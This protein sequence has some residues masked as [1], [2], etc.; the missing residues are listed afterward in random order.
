MVG[1]CRAPAPPLRPGNLAF[2]LGSPN[3]LGAYIELLVPLS[4]V[5]VLRWVRARAWV[6]VLIGTAALAL[7]ATTSR[8]AAL[9]MGCGFVAFVGLRWSPQQGRRVLILTGM[10]V[11]GLVLAIPFLSRFAVGDAGRLELWHAAIDIFARWP[12]LGGG[13][14]SWPSLRPLSPITPSDT[15]VIATAHDA[16][17][18]VMAE[19]GIVGV[20]TASIV[21]VSVIAIAI[22]ARRATTGGERLRVDACTASLV[23]VAVHAL[24]DPMFHLA[25]VVVL[26]LYLVAQLEAATPTPISRPRVS[27]RT[28]RVLVGAWVIVAAVTL[29]RV[30]SAMLIA[31]GG[32]SALDRGDAANA[33]EAYDA[34]LALDDRD[35]YRLGG[36]SPWRIWVGPPRP[37]Q[38]SSRSRTRS[39]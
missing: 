26:V 17:L 10:S 36:P 35:G 32:D 30:D 16:P 6:A 9:G 25:G 13:P 18:Y 8:G 7:V 39:H 22:R 38:S 4:V 5:I 1:G 29:G 15:A 28:K 21:V 11:A 34:A 19:L 20:I 12:L 14:G 31:S 37:W 24:V 23:A 3:V 27:D 33:M 2:T